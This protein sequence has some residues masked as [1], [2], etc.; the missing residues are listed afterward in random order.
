[1]GYRF[2][3]KALHQYRE[4][5]LKREQITLAQALQRLEALEMER[6]Q[7]RERL[8]AESIDFEK[9]QCEGMGVPDFLACGDRIQAMEQHLLRLEREVLE[10]RTEAE[11]AQ[12]NVLERER[13]LRA[14]TILEERE[15]ESYN[16]DMKKKEQGHIDE[17]AILGTGRRKDDSGSS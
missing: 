12:R 13:D 1:M 9:R 5:L 11:S 6:A 14:L 4:F 16:H 8:K 15:R 3:F 17:F 7:A 2:R 10:L